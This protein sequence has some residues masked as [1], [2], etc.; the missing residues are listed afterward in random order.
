MLTFLTRAIFLS[1][2]YSLV[3]LLPRVQASDGPAFN[4]STLIYPPYQYLENEEPKGIAIDIIQEAMKRAGSYRVNFNFYPW[5]R[6]VYLT[7]HGQS[8]LLFNAGK[9]R[10]RQKWGRYV[11]SVLIE[12]RYVLFKRKQHVFSI[13]PEYAGSEDKVISVRRGY[14]YGDG[15]FRQALDNHRF[16]AVSYSDSTKQSVD[17]LLN[18]RIDMFVGDQLP[19]LFYIKE[20]GLED[21]IDIVRHGGEKLE[22][23]YWPTYILFSKERSTPELIDKVNKAM[24]SM[25]LDGSFDGIIKRYA[26]Q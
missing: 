18:H 25:K 21:Q 22:V 11:Q 20:Q 7:E 10:A 23:L 8:D 16:S 1:L 17:Q 15:L 14:L 19:V 24:E 6:A 9:N 2:I 12:Q 5:K 4:A 26:S 13:S 3:L